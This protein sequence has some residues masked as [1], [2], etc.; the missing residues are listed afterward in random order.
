MG[1][2]NVTPDSFSDGGRYNSL[3]TALRHAG[4]MLTDGAYLIDIGGE[5]TRPGADPVSEDEELARVIPVVE[6][7]AS[8]FDVV[9]SVDT[10]NAAVMRESARAGAHLINDVRSLTREG[11]LAAAAA[12]GLP[13]CIMHMNGEPQVMQQ[14]PHYEVPIEEAVSDFLQQHI[15]RCVLGG[16]ERS[17]LLL[18]PGFGFG[19]TFA[20]NYRLL[21]RLQELQSFGLPLLTGLSRKRMI[22]Q[23]T[24]AGDAADRVSGS[25]TAAVICAQ[26]GANIVRVHDVKQTVEALNVVIATQREGNV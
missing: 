24:G 20:H 13:V 19:K 16:I 17:R 11:A 23:A 15:D 21:N 9:V 22:G 4:Q 26:K 8:R 12:T 1:I 18:D 5:S 6:A 2:L 25:V 7:I 10:S 3:D 14:A